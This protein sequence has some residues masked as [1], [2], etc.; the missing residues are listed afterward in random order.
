MRPGEGHLG[1][2]KEWLAERYQPHEN[3]PKHKDYHWHVHRKVSA[4][5]PKAWDVV[6]SPLSRPMHIRVGKGDDKLPAGTLVAA[7]DHST[8]ASPLK[9]RGHAGGDRD[10]WVRFR[11][12]GNEPDKKDPE[13]PKTRTS[14]VSRH[15]KKEYVVP[16]QAYRMALQPPMDPKGAA[17]GGGG[18]PPPG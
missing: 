18:A 2:F 7:V 15:H 12:V 9:K 3:P 16:A 1:G 13:V 5:P 17:G 10:T 6:P 11:V 14:L 8:D 4:P